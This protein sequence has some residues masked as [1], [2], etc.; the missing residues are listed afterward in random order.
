MENI[1]INDTILKVFPN[2][3]VYKYGFKGSS[4]EKTWHCLSGSIHTKKNGYKRHVIGINGI[5]YC[6]ARLLGYAFLRFDLEDEED[7]I[8][9]IS[10]NSID[11]HISNLRCASKTLQQLNKNK[12]AKGWALTPYGKYQALITIDNKSISL[13]N[14]DTKEEA[15]QVFLVERN[16]RLNE[17]I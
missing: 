10:I 11:N 3:E 14:Y 6:T 9:H 12:Q 16:K 7:S 13:G 15:H 1:F 4:K 17:I 5:V 8:D 2:G